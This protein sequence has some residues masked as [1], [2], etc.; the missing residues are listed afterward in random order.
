[1]AHRQCCRH[2]DDLLLYF[3]QS[4]H[5][6]FAH[7]SLENTR[8]NEVTLR[9]S[10]FIFLSTR[11]CCLC[12][13]KRTDSFKKYLLPV[14]VRVNSEKMRGITEGGQIKVAAPVFR[15]HYIL[16]SLFNVISLLYFT[17]KTFRKTRTVKRN[18][19]LDS[20]S[21]RT[22]EY[23]FSFGSG[24]QE[25]SFVWSILSHSSTTIGRNGVGQWSSR[26]EW[27]CCCVHVNW[28]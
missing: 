23:Y 10:L 14:A 6:I 12:L 17:G 24:T 28:D 1:M 5:W 20:I 2:H 22:S 21:H 25:L 4:Q 15:S 7:A 27:K 19:I 18:L 26:G 8:I 13:A 16:R 3:M 11:S 9:P